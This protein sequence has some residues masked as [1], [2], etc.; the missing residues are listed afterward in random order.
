MNDKESQ[1]TKLSLH[2]NTINLTQS[3]DED[4]EEETFRGL[5]IDFMANSSGNGLPAVARASGSIIRRLCWVVLCL[6]GTGCYIF[7]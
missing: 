2:S 7:S 5:F 1:E 3:E 6:A 4:E